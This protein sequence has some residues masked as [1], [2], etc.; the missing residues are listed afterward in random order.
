MRALRSCVSRTCTALSTQVVGVESL[1]YLD[2]WDRGH[3]CAT[4]GGMYAISYLIICMYLIP[5]LQSSPPCNPP[6]LH[7]FIR[8]SMQSP[9]HVSNRTVCRVTS[10]WRVSSA[11]FSFLRFSTNANNGPCPL[12]PSSDTPPEDEGDI[13]P[14]PLRRPGART[15]STHRWS[16]DGPDGRNHRIWLCLTICMLRGQHFICALLLTACSVPLSALQTTIQ[17]YLLVQ[18]WFAGALLCCN[19]IDSQWC[20]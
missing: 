2:F 11:T 9:Y 12:S 4:G 13:D 14:P 8:G 17:C 1:F 16:S 3:A 20:V 18:L 10:L 15:D 7:S 19:S 5:P 6:P